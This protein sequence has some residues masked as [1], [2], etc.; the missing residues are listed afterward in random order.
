MLVSLYTSRVFLNVLGVVDY[1]INNVVCGFVLMFSF[2]NSSLANGIQRFYNV[3]IGRGN[4]TGVSV[5]YSTSLIIQLFIALF[6]VVLLETVGVWY[7][8]TKMVIPEERRYVAFWIFQL[9]AVSSVITFMQSCYL[10]AVMAYEKMDFYALLSIIDVGLKLL[11]ALMIPYLGIDH[12]LSLGIFMLVVQVINYLCNYLYCM[13]KFPDLRIL[14]TFHKDMYVNMLSFSG[15]NLLGTFA[16]MLREQGL[17]LIINLF[18]GPA[19][20][21]ARSVAYQV[22][23][24]IQ[25]L[26]QNISLAAKPQMITSFSQG[27]SRR[28]MQLMYVMTKLNFMVLYAI[29]VPIAFEIDY[30]L[31]LWLGEIIPTHTASFIVLIIL[32]S[33][34]N[35][36][37]APL[38][39]VVYATGKMK[40]YELTFSTINILILPA[41]YMVL[42]FGAPVE[43]VFVIYLFFSVFVQIGCLLVLRTLVDINLKEYCYIIVFP[44]LFCTFISIPIPALLHHTMNQGILRLVVVT[45]SSIMFSSISFYYVVLD[46]KEKK[47]TVLALQ[48]VRERICSR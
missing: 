4:H 32:I 7:F 24:A 2:L 9:S 41:S 12:L 1:G 38:S 33:F 29:A 3:E 19:V 25:G 8:E 27:D 13:K 20:N 15:W 45:L 47:V 34:M 26:V 28:T 46:T 22:S 10:A 36:L 14:R 6:V 31:K 11:F 48:K 16:C 44:I 5:V 37:N 39:N 30:I 40:N 21:A 18:F 43:S 42:R 23:A 35:N 17:N